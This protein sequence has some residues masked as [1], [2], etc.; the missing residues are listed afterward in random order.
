MT[1]DTTT[2]T[3]DVPGAR[4]T[5][6]VRRTDQSTGPLLLMIGFP[7]AAAGFGT[8]AGHFDERTVVTCD[9]RG[10]ERSTVDDVSTR[11]SPSHNADDLHRLVHHLDEGPVDVFAS[12]GGAVNALALVAAHPDDVRTLVAH[13]PPILAALPDRDNATAAAL[14]VHEDY[15]RDGFGAGMARFIALTNHQGEFPDDWADQPAPDPAMFG[16]PT[17]DD[18]SRDDPLLSPGSTGI[19]H[20]DPD[21]AAIRAAPTR[22]VMAA[23]VESEG[24]LA[25]RAAVGVAGELGRE[26]VVFPSNHGGFLGGEYGQAGEP[27]AF[28]TRLHE[29]LDG[30]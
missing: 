11:P 13:E 20:H 15:V 4:L 2:Q 25:Q 24:Q 9:P 5:F 26:V 21:Y 12:S 28:A 27:E 17:D 16:L 22:V 8:L 7:M 14:A 30:Q 10:I 3:L 1:T 29:V 6:D 19:Q 18:G 23:G